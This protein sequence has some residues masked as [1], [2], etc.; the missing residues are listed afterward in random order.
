MVHE[1]D[2]PN[3]VVDFFDSEFLTGEHDRDI[4]LFPVHADAARQ[5]S[6]SASEATG[7]LSPRNKSDVQSDHCKIN[8]RSYLTLVGEFTQNG[9]PL[10]RVLMPSPCLSRV[11]PHLR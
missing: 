7:A 1:S 5:L 11:H 9:R 3:A 6:M 4:D 8:T 10:E 2:E